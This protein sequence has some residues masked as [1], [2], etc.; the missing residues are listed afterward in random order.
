MKFANLNCLDLH[1]IWMLPSIFFVS[2]FVLLKVV[3]VEKGCMGTIF[4]VWKAIAIQIFLEK[5]QKIDLVHRPEI[6]VMKSIWELYNVILSQPLHRPFIFLS[7]FSKSTFWKFKWSHIKA[8]MPLAALV[9]EIKALWRG[10][11]KPHCKFPKS[12]S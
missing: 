4:S 8:E 10:C 3:W 12:I 7:R 1:P 6:S 9:Y 5:F 2:N 11:D